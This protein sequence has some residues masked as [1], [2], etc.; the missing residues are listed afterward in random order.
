[1]ACMALRPAWTRS[2]CSRYG[3]L[4]AVNL[5]R[6]RSHS[7]TLFIFWLH[8]YNVRLTKFWNSDRNH[9]ALREMFSFLQQSLSL[10][11]LTCWISSGLAI[12]VRDRP[13]F[14]IF[15][16]KIEQRSCVIVKSNSMQFWGYWRF[17]QIRQRIFNCIDMQ[18]MHFILDKIL[19]LLTYYIYTPF[20]YHYQSLQSY[21]ISKTVRF[22]AH[23]V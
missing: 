2:R 22:L 4:P 14:T 18:I 5:V 1:M 10:F 15:Q 19:K 17:M 6:V 21:L 8:K 16:I 13:C 3:E 11:D 7:N 23:P 12:S 20:Y 9:N